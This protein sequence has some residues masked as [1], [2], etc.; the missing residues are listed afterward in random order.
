MKNLGEFWAVLADRADL[1]S[2]ET[3]F[4]PWKPESSIIGEHKDKVSWH[5]KRKEKKRGIDSF[6]S[7][8]LGKCFA[9]SQ[10]KLYNTT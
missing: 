10:L 3:F 1:G 9:K 6:L 2:I 7:F 5:K 8:I 4:W